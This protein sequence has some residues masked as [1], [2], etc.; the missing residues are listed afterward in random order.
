MTSYTPFETM[1]A[2]TKTIIGISNVEFCIENIFNFLNICEYEII[3]KKRGR[4]K[5]NEVQKK[6]PTLEEGSIVTLKYQDNMKGVNLKRSSSSNH[7]KKYFRNALTVVMFIQG[8]FINFKLSKNGKFQITGVKKTKNAI[9][10]IKY[11]WNLIKDG[12][13]LF[14]MNKTEPTFIVKFLTVMTNIDFNVG[15]NINREHLDTYINKNTN[16]NSLLEMSFGYTGVN[17]KFPLKN[18]IDFYLPQIQYK[19][20]M[21][22]EDT[23]LYSQYI[24][25]LSISEQKKIQNKK[26]YN[27]FLVFHSGNVIM[28][29]M[30]K[31]FMKQEYDNFRKIIIDSKSYIEEKLD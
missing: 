3:P 13:N 31:L 30:I 10:C 17:I 25:S 21:W 29:G 2:S 28:S 12:D 16:F 1:T 14:N 20:N 9:E 19:D 4:R 11:F 5:K 26:R 22:I 6:E 18:N 24:N 27:T 23:I 7:K 8:K 15:F